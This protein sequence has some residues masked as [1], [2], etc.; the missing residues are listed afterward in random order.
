MGSGVINFKLDSELK[1]QFQELAKDLGS[2]TTTL[3]TMFIKRAVDD[4]AI[5]FEVKA[6]SKISPHLRKLLA[7]EDAKILGIIEDDATSLTK[8]ERNKYRDLYK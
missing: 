3:M 8:N 5:P 1:E 7:E 2:N 6:K 4:Q